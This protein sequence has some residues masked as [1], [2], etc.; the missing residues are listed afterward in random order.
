MRVIGIVGAEGKKFTS[1]TEEQAKFLITKI[2][3]QPGVLCSGH[4]HLGGIDIW[5]EEIAKELGKYDE[6]YIHAPKTLSWSSGFK[7]RNIAIA[8]DSH[9]IHNIVVKEYPPGFKGMRFNG[10]YHC[11]TLRPPHVKSGG[12]WTAN[13]AEEYG[14]KAYWY[15][16]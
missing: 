2:L 8:H 16:L 11:G 4:C 15:I 5:A 10:C 7:P 9:E 6:R 12:C 1:A 3:S 14:K 13:K